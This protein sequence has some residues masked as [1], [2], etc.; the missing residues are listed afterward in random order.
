MRGVTVKNPLA[1]VLAWRRVVLMI[2]GLPLVI[3]LAALAYAWPAS[4][5]APRDLPVGIVG[6]SAASQSAVEG[7]TRNVPGGFDFHLYPDQTSARSAIM[8][9]EV[10]GAFVIA[11]GRVTVLEATAASTSVAQLL[12]TSGQQL[13]AHAV[14]L[15]QKPFVPDVHDA[16]HRPNGR[17]DVAKAPAKVTVKTVDV[18]PTSAEDPRGVVFT[19]ALLPLTICGILIAALITLSTLHLP[20]WRRVI[21]LI[22]VCAVGGLAAYLVAQGILGALPHNHLATYASLSLTLLAISATSAGLIRLLG[23][24]GLGASAVLMVFVGNPFSGSTSAPELLPKAVDDIG[25]WLPPGAGA[26]LMRSTAYFDGN[27][28][29][30]HIA[31]LVLWCVLGLTSVV[32][33]RR[34]LTVLG[35]TVE[36]DSHESHE[37]DAHA[38]DEPAGA[39]VA[40]T[41]GAAAASPSGVPQDRHAHH[42][43]HALHD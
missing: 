20:G 13:A 33:A 5:I 30:S 3:S 22:A 35:D 10:Y 42:A 38:A 19:A 17:K 23:H 31:V 7:M 25:Q 2:V 37:S 27:A 11:P 43:R 4:R 6:T 39:L 21:D 40:A 8:N 28:S 15:P 34:T 24:P 29:G 36:E 9:R 14:K 41:A 16:S 18:V 32:F 1:R 26:N 12:R